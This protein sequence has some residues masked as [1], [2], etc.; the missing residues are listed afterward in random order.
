MLGGH[1][2]GRC[3]ADIDDARPS[4]GQNRRGAHAFAAAIRGEQDRLEA[5][6]VEARKM[7]RDAGNGGS[8]R[9]PEGVALHE[10]SRVAAAA[11]RPRSRR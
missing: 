8:T 5:V 6:A 3:C 2:T 9:S 4:S 7:R 1:R 10:A 11:W